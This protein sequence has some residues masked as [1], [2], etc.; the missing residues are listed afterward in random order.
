[1]AVVNAQG[2]SQSEGGACHLR[3]SKEVRWPGGAQTQRN[4]EA[5]TGMYSVVAECGQ[6]GE[7]RNPNPEACLRCKLFDAKHTAMLLVKMDALELLR[8]QVGATCQVSSAQP[9][10]RGRAS[11]PTFSITNFHARPL[12]RHRVTA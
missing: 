9:I 12:A 2:A 8:R 10:V 1:M 4:E 11:A 6:R 5:V 3:A 7:E